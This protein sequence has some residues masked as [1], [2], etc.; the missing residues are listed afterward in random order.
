[1]GTARQVLSD[2]MREAIQAYFPRYPTRR[3]ALLP[4]L[5]VVNEGL[6]YV[7]LEAVVEL[8]GLL[9]CAPAEVQDAIS[10]YGFFKQDAP[11]GRYRVWVCR[12]ISCAAC[13]GETLL[14]HLSARLGVKPGQTS[15]DGRVS[16]E[17]AECLGGCD[18]APAILVN[19]TL[20]KNM[21]AEKIDALVA[22]WSP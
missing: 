3:A 2:A 13:G 15:A 6:G 4:A 5:H 19:D 16:L 8:A 20:Y 18:F 7:P 11:Q 14:E 12:S 17:F 10:F 1:M 9:Q 22:S 21:T